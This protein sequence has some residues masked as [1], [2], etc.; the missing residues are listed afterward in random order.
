[1]L[2]REGVDVDAALAKPAK[3]GNAAASEA[4]AAEAA[5]AEADA[6]SGATEAAETAAALERFAQQSGAGSGSRSSNGG[7]AS[8]GDSGAAKRFDLEAFRR[9]LYDITGAFGR[10]GVRR[11][12]PTLERQRQYLAA[13]SLRKI[14][15]YLAH[16]SAVADA[17]GELALPV[18][19]SFGAHAR[20]PMGPRLIAAAATGEASANSDGTASRLTIPVTLLYGSH[21]WMD[22]RAGAATA[23]ALRRAGLDAACLIT[24]QAGHHLY[25]EQPAIFCNQ[26]LGRLAEA[27]GRASRGGGGSGWRRAGASAW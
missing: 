18:L 17:S 2:E 26:V 4:A 5:Q 21:D 3:P 25:M 27:D 16:L 13:N 6:L 19:L 11:A 23:D 14:A 22:A 8:A 24:P 15:S 7:A 10:G 9:Y 1:M 20:V 12:R